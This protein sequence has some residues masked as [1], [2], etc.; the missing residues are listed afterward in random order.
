[1]IIR[2]NSILILSIYDNRWCD[3]TMNVLIW[4]MYVWISSCFVLSKLNYFWFFCISDNAMVLWMYGCMDGWMYICLF[5]VL[6]ELY[7]SWC[8]HLPVLNFVPQICGH[9]LFAIFFPKYFCWQIFS[10]WWCW[11]SVVT[12]D[13][14]SPVVLCIWNLLYSYSCDTQRF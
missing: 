12:S 1:M 10:L 5:F 8:L 6:S 9:H 14:L 3:G 2:L 4:W 13:N 7:Y 11:F